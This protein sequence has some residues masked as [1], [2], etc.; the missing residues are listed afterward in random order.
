MTPIN[1]LKI[2]N[3]LCIT[4]IVQ[5]GDYGIQNPNNVYV[6]LANNAFT[7]ALY[8]FVKINGGRKTK[9]KNYTIL[10]YEHAHVHYYLKLAGVINVITLAKLFTLFIWG[11]LNER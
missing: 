4:K 10:N 1:W 11:R 7:N 3:N 5:L 9:L 8:T 6:A 2:Y